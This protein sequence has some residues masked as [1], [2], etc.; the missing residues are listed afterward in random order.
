MGA[1]GATSPL[2]EGEVR[3]GGVRSP[4]LQ[5]GPEESREAVVL[6]HGNPGSSRD[7]EN[8]IGRVGPF[9]RAVALDM[10]GFGRADKPASFD[11]TVDGYARYLGAALER[12]GVDRAHLVLHDFGGPWGLTWAAAEPDRFASIVLVNTGVLLGYRW[13]SLARIWRTPVLGEAF[14]AASTRSGWRRAMGNTEPRGLPLPF[15]DRMYDDFDWGTRRAVL[16][17]YRATDEPAEAA[18]ELARVLG[19]LARPALVV[20]GEHDAFIPVEQAHRQKEVFEDAEIVVLGES[21]HWPFADD[22]AGVAEAVVPFLR[23]ATGQERRDE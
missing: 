13:H 4:V 23:R 17:L 12:L 5:S 19:P 7:W 15:V 20:W 8:L 21:G 16:K 3:V 2:R 18:E 6:V 9:A 1:S 11:Y 22:P 14:M 10:P